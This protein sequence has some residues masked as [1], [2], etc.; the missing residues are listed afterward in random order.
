MKI[1][2]LDDEEIRHQCFAQMLGSEHELWHAYTPEQFFRQLR[3]V[4]KFDVVSFDH[5]LGRAMDGDDCAKEMLR[6]PD[7]RW[8]DQCWV[9]SW[10]P[11]GAE[12][13]MRTL[14]ASGIPTLRRPFAAGEDA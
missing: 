3:R 10:N 4:E 1:L 7:D 2:I 5:D 8:P 11:V 6:L 9:H 13:I 12:R 14:M